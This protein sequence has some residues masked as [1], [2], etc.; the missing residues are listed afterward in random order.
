[1]AAVES[2]AVVIAVAAKLTNKL[3]DQIVDSSFKSASFR[4]RPPA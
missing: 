1:M 2:N 4:S 3:S